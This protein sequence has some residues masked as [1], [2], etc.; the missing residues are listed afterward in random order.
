MDTY[1][2]GE[3]IEIP[4]TLTNPSTGVEE[5]GVPDA[6]IEILKGSTQIVAPTPLIL[7]SGGR[8]TFSYT[9][10]LSADS[11]IYTAYITATVA[12]NPITATL[13]FS[14]SDKLT[15][16]QTSVDNIMLDAA[17][18]KADL[19]AQLDS[20]HQDIGDPSSDGT[21]LHSELKS[22]IDDLGNPLTT[23]QDITEK[24]DDIRTV[25]GLGT[26]V[27][28][29][30]VTGT[31]FDDNA[32]P[33]QGVRVIAVNKA[34]G[35]A[36]DTDTTNNVGAYEL[37]LNPGEY[38]LEFVQ[39]QTVLQ[40]TQVLVVPTLITTLTVPAITLATKRTVTDLIQDPNHNPIPG[41]LV[42]AI[43]F[44]NFDFNAADN[45]V[46]AAAFTDS[47]GQFTIQLFPGV[48]MFQFIKI[49]FD[50]LPQ[51]VTVV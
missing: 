28:I 6:M 31:V 40:Q 25:L 19:D 30:T 43:L 16:L 22:I 38:V 33:I 42:K 3:T 10:P 32:M 9:I 50:T 44:A 17:V 2:K 37:H 24:L 20:I 11:G 5:I 21:D 39:A 7:I 26:P 45:Q 29:V 46:E 18:S 35:N 4:V 49:G 8:F 48:Y 13:D 47:N 34:T 15:T 23:G 1:E 14:V 36:S 27:G 51:K 12:G 41:V